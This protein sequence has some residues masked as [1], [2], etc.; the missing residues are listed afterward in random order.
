[1]VKS[2][3]KPQFSVT[4]YD[5]IEVSEKRYNKESKSYEFLVQ[6]APTWEPQTNLVNIFR[7]PGEELVTLPFSDTVLKKPIT[8]PAKKRT[9]LTVDKACQAEIPT[10]P[11]ALPR[12]ACVFS[13]S[14]RVRPSNLGFDAIR[15]IVGVRPAGGDKPA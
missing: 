3:K 13:F 2:R 6:W 9:R 4:H 15:N 8:A 5:I 7:L 14:H 1:M 10:S 12:K 11:V